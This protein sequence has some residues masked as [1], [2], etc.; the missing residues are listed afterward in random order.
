MKPNISNSLV[1]DYGRQ[2]KRHNK[3]RAFLSSEATYSVVQ[4]KVNQNS[5]AT[6]LCY[7]GKDW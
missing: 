5:E 4:L 1:L 3:S 6:S 2:R 7:K